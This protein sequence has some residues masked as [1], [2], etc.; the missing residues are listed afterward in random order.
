MVC[1]KCDKYKLELAT[2]QQKWELRDYCSGTERYRRDLRHIKKVPSYVS[3]QN[4]CDEE[5]KRKILTKTAYIETLLN[6]SPFKDLKPPRWCPKK[7][8]KK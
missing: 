5:R 7:E 6:S 2:K 8:E 3:Y 4:E 1:D